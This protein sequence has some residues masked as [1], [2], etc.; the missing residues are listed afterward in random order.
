L[1]A[2]STDVEFV[3]RP[4]PHR[5]AKREQGQ[6]QTV[7]DLIAIGKRR[8]MKNPHGWARHVLA[9]RQARKMA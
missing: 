7:E 6:A 5:E 8:G 1:S 2:W 9:A 3:S 4:D